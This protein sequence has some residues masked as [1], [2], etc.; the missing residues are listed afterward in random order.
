MS[1]LTNQ[2]AILFVLATAIAVLARLFRQP[3]I[4][5]YLATGG[6]IAYFGFAEA[7]GSETFKLFSNLGIMFLLFLV[8]LEINYTSLRLVGKHALISGLSQIAITASL[9]FLLT[10]LLGFSLFNGLY[11][12]VALT[13]SS[14][15][16]II[17]LLSDKKDINSL[18]GKLAVGM[19][20]VQDMVAISILVILTGIQGSGS[21]EIFGVVITLVKAALLFGVT[22]WLGR[23]ILPHLFDVIAHSQELLFLASTAWVFLVAMIVNQVGFSIEIAGFLAGL[24]LANSSENFQIANRIRPLRDFFILIFFIVL[25]ATLTITN[26]SGLGI[27]VLVLSLF[28]LV[29]NPLILLIIMGIMGFRKRT[30]FLTGLTM[31]QVSE[32]SLIMAALGLALGHI[33]QQTVTI[34]TAVAIISITVSSYLIT[35]GNNIFR[36]LKNILWIFERKIT[37]EATLPKEMKQPIILIGFHRTGQSLAHSLPAKDLIVVDFDPEMSKKLERYNYHHIFGD[38]S[39]P[40]IFEQVA[41]YKTK[42]VISTSP[43]LEDN[44]LLISRFKTIKPRPSI[45]VRAESEKEALIFY[46]TGADYVLV[47]H[48]TS[49][50]RLGHLLEKHPT[51]AAFKKLK[52]K[53]LKLIARDL[54][55]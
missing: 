8:G 19:L 18:Y 10:R 6:L 30:S 38:I 5:A 3:L 15:I 27:P 28:V 42:L 44:L 22:I 50:H 16:I 25:G 23:K 51:S 2:L 1:D 49:A 4:L 37:S 14:T 54:A 9:G 7:V 40:E 33:N 13:F 32:F 45:I 24:G 11:I 17:K 21:I 35:H 12:A 41:S 47:P 20:L 26:I 55:D 43:D 48:L 31:G 46:Q 39:D 34:I 52:T 53:D 29:G 36:I